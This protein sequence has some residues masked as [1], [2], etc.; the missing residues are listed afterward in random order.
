LGAELFGWGSIV[1]K[2]LLIK[3]KWARRV[4]VGL[5]IVKNGDGVEHIERFYTVVML[6]IHENIIGTT[7]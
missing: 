7:G 3:C 1:A 5:A 4:S 2:I 6:V